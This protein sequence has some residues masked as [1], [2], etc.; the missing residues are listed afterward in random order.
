MCDRVTM[1]RAKKSGM[2]KKDYRKLEAIKR[3]QWIDC[4]FN[5][6][7]QL[8]SRMEPCGGRMKRFWYAYRALGFP[9]LISEV[10]KSTNPDEVMADLRE[11][12]V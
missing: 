1:I 2:S 8:R 9:C 6:A 5:P 4:P 11:L 10:H 7:Y 12:L 3:Q